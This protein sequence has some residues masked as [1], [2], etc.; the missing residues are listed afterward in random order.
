MNFKD[1]EAIYLQIADYITEHITLGKWKPDEKIPSV[2]EMAG[3]L[4]VNPNTVMRTY[5]HLQNQ[6]IVFNKRGM[7]HYVAADAVD[8]IKSIRRERFLQQDLPDFFKSLYLLD[9]SLEELQK[10][11][12]EY[13]SKNYST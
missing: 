8:K 6:E 11:Y 1:K 4:Q 9:I 10:R 5:E 3:D 2:R 13:R 7:G 12:D